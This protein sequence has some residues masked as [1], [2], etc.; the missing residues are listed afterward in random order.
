MTHD[1]FHVFIIFKCH[2]NVGVAII[3]YLSDLSKQLRRQIFMQGRILGVARGGASLPIFCNHL[4]F[5][6]HFEELQ[7]VLFEVEL[8]INN[9]LLTYAYPNT[10]ETCYT[11]SF[12][13]LQA[14]IKFF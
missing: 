14:V 3:I 12:V 2:S 5:C 13:I 9:A 7:T 8:S 11:Q 10:T 1:G 6:N 4:F